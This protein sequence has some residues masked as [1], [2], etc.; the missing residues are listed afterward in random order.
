MSHQVSGLI[1]SAFLLNT[2][3]PGWTRIDVFAEWS[4]LL[5]EES[6]VCDSSIFQEVTEIIVI[7]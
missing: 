6:P 3:S 1:F 7:I 2:P 5:S 4:A